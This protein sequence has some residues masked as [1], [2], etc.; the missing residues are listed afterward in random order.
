MSGPPAPAGGWYK[1]S[2]LARVQNCDFIPSP[3]AEAERQAFIDH[4]EGRPSTPAEALPL[5]A[6]D[7]ML[8]AAEVI[9][10]LLDDP[11]ILAGERAWPKAPRD[12]CK[13]SAHYRGAH[14]ARD[15]SLPGGRR[16]SGE[17]LLQPHRLTTHVTSDE[18]GGAPGGPPYLDDS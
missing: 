5:G 9:R 7:R 8:H 12:H 4:G 1:V 15:P 3:L 10:D 11:D 18:R 14:L 2:P 6:H 16:R 13:A 17:R